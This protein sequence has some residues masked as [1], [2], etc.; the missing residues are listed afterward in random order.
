MSRLKVLLI[1]IF[2]LQCFKLSAQSPPFFVIGAEEF[3]NV[4]IYSLIYED[5]TDM[6]YAGTNRGIFVYTQNEFR[7]LNGSKKQIDNSFFQLK[8]NKNGDLFCCNLHGQIFKIENRNLKLFHEM[9]YNESKK[10]FRYYFDDK[11]NLIFHNARTIRKLT[12]D[13]IETILYNQGLTDRVNRDKLVINIRSSYQLTNGTICFGGELTNRYLTYD[14]GK[15][16]EI[17]FSDVAVDKGVFV[18]LGEEVFYSSI[19]QLSLLE[20]KALQS[21]FAFN[22]INPN[23][24]AVLNLKLGLSFIEVIDTTITLTSSAFKNKFVSSISSNG[25]GTMF[26]GT[27]KEGVIVIP[28]WNIIKYRTESLFSGIAS[29]LTNEVYLSNKKE[30]YKHLNGLHRIGKFNASIDHIFF[31]EG[32]YSVKEELISGI[33]HSRQ[34]GMLIEKIFTNVK[35]LEESESEVIVFIDPDKVRI[36]SNS[37]LILDSNFAIKETKN[38][39][40]IPLTNHR[41]YSVTYNKEEQYLYYST[42]ENVYAKKWN[43][44]ITDTLRFNGEKIQGNDLT[45]HKNYLIIGSEK[46]GVLFYENKNFI[47]KIGSNEG[48]KANTVVKLQ[49]N[50]NLL[51]ILTTSGLQVYNLNSK[52]FLGIGERE[53]I[54][55]EKIIDFALSSDKI[56]LLDKEGYYSIDLVQLKS[57]EK[58]TLGEV[59]LDSVVV[60]N[61]RRDS[62][63][64]SKLSHNENSIQ[65]FFDYR[66]LETLQEAKFEYKLQGVSEGWVILPTNVNTIAFPA[67]SPGVYNFYIKVKYRNEETKTLEYRFEIFQPFWFQLWFLLLSI[68]LIVFLV[69]IFFYFKMKKNARNRKVEAEKQ[70]MQTDI[71]ESKLKAIRSQMNPHFIFNSLNSIQALVLKNETKKSYDYIEMFSDLV[72]KTLSFSEKNY[73]SVIEEIEF[74]RIYLTLETLR[75]KKEF[76]FS[77]ANNIEEEIMIPTLLIQPFL[78]NA[79]HHGLLHKLGNKNL[80]ISFSFNQDNNTAFCTII[81]NG[82]GRVKSKEINNRQKYRHESFSLNAT[83]ER[84][85]ILSEQNNQNFK[86]IIEDLYNEEDVATGTKVVVSF[87]FRNKY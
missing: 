5:E 35:D 52:Q 70:K 40:S 17:K 58:I 12:P 38:L 4:D 25:N 73:T 8:K 27:F 32:N 72:R 3:S 16:E 42:S 78:E 9:P 26:L 13:G 63:N 84:L 61:E 11:N 24:V 76:E 65:F 41:G 20:N 60:N 6:L 75:M 80:L 47:W 56:W 1:I 45:H 29:S 10:G 23:K 86:Y 66:D 50:Q 57:N 79:I 68:F 51:F 37:D 21:S 46:E 62:F 18:E 22:Q 85:R 81:D 55:T 59:Y 77:I 87:P 82:I 44:G 36:I 7:P 74:L 48:L 30:L 67:L 14:N 28:N 31:L 19:P 33:I 69:S 43:S 54:M 64:N 2:F 53:G 83:E 34:G 49:I 15:M 39:F 71:F